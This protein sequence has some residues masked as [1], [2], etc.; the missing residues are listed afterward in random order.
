VLGRLE[1]HRLGEPGEAVLGADVAALKG[2]ATSA[3]AEAMLTMRPQPFFFIAGS[4]SR[5]V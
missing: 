2:E 4:A 3:C 1:R 5:V